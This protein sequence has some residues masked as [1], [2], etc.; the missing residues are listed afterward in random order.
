MARTGIIAPLAK[1]ALANGVSVDDLVE[2]HPEID[3]KALRRGYAQ[4][5]TQAKRKANPDAPRGRKKV[6]K[7]PRRS[8]LTK[9]LA[10]HLWH[11]LHLSMDRRQAKFCVVLCLSMGPKLFSGNRRTPILSSPW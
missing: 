2:S 9:S 8:L 3:E 6:A 1:E 5:K 7:N 4:V 10:W 11:P